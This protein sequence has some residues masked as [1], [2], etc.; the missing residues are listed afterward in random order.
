MTTADVTQNRDHDDDGGRAD[1]RL[2]A[3]EAH[4]GLDNG[5]VDLTA[6]IP[7]TAKIGVWRIEPSG[8]YALMGLMDDPLVKAAAKQAPNN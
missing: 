1:H 4:D 6:P 8:H 3:D 5:D 2:G 7:N